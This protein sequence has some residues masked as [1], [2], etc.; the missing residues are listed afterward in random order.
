M[1]TLAGS[2]HGKNSYASKSCKSVHEHAPKSKSKIS[3]E[4]HEFVSKSKSKF[5]KEGHEVA[6]KSKS[7]FLKESM[8]LHQGK[9]SHSE[10]SSDGT[11]AKVAPPDAKAVKHASSSWSKSKSKSKSKGSKRL[12]P[13]NHQDH[14]SW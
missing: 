2:K 5:F 8:S 6:V 10:Q 12:F 14:T 4:N 7:K 1:L 9:H 13:K 11:S 3:K